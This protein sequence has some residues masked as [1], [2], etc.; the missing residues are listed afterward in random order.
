MGFASQ[1][2]EKK[3]KS[4]VSCR[5]ARHSRQKTVSMNICPCK[6]SALFS[7]CTVSCTY[8]VS[9]AV[10]ETFSNWISLSHTELV[11]GLGPL[12]TA[13]LCQSKSAVGCL[14]GLLTRRKFSMTSEGIKPDTTKWRKFSMTSEDIKPHT[15]T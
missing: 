12:L 10:R 15:K 6:Y 4:E 7:A 9:F 14:V 11:A 13:L 5:D 2:K 3:K 1:K 8:C